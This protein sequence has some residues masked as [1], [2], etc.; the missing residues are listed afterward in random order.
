VKFNIPGRSPYGRAK[1][2]IVYDNKANGFPFSGAVITNSVSST[3]SGPFT[4]LG[5]SGVQLSSELSGIPVANEYK[6]RARIQYDLVTNPYQK[7][8]P[9]KYY[10]NNFPVSFGGFKPKE[11]P[12]SIKTLNLTILIQ[13][14][15][16]SG[17]DAMIPD[18]VWTYLRNSSSPYPVID[19]S[20]A[21]VNSSGQGVF[22][23]ANALNSVNYFLDV[24]HR[25]SIETWSKT[26]PVFTSS[27]MT[28]NFTSADTQAFGNNLIGIN[29]T[30]QKYGI[31]SGDQNQDGFVNLTD[32]VNVFNNANAFVNG[33][34]DT[35]MNGDNITDLSDIVITFNN[36]GAFVG[37]VTP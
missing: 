34:V 30:P 23:F 37:K 10:Q 18:T 13:G 7:F 28:Y 12:F 22:N 24:R 20:K 6:W 5:N 21:V 2:K 17:S 8:G 1:G 31:Y 26:A 11:I 9:W 19:S 35:D 15:Y 25:N 33:Y 27:Q 16:D 3:G 29:T 36:A 32:V 4:D 14:F